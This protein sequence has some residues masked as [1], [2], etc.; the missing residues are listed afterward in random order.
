M[1]NSFSTQN[2]QVGDTV[3][4]VRAGMCGDEYIGKVM[5]KTPDGRVD[6]KYRKNVVTRYRSDGYEYC[7]YYTYNESPTWLEF[8]TKERVDVLMERSKRNGILNFL[9]ER[10]WNTYEDYELE[11]I[12][13][14]IKGLRRI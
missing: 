9:R 11:H 7:N 4:V 8:G 10:D 6:V 5:K 2:L 1:P 12:Y 14:F 3:I 13:H